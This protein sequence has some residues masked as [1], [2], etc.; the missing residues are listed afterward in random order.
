[1]KKTMFRWALCTLAFLPLLSVAQTTDP[2]PNT[3][4]SLFGGGGLHY[5]TFSLGVNGGITAPSVLIGGSNDFTKS[6]IS[7]GY[8]AYA[9]WQ[10]LHFFSL[11]ADYMGGRLKGD[12][13]RELGNGAD[14]NRAVESF[15][16]RLKWTASLSGVF[17]F[18]TI[19]WAYR[20]PLAQFYASVGGGLA[21]YSP[22][23]TPANGTEQEYKPDGN[24]KEL[25]IPVGAGIK[26]RLNDFLN[27][28]L[29][30]TMHFVDGDNL[31]GFNYGNS[32]D[33]FSYGY[34][35][36]E[37][38]LGARTKPQLQWHN[39]PAVMYDDLAAQRDQLRLELEAEKNNNAKLA[40]DLAKLQADSDGDGVSDVFDKCPNTPSGD[41]V[42]GS[43]CSLPKPDTARPVQV[44]ITEDDRRLVKNAIDNLEF[45]TGKSDIRPKSYASLNEVA[46]LM[47]RKNLSLK[48]AGHTDNTGNRALNMRLSKDR[49]E[50]VKSYLVS[51]GVNPSRIEATGYGQ[52]QPI[53]SNK[54]A[55]GRQQNRRVEFTIY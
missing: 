11:R 37:F 44:I 18:G 54:T 23:I 50:S 31:D 42:D 46:A 12:Q 3:H 40:A 9:K 19:N 30:Y 43:G 36:L 1:M 47:V 25:V 17:N 28:D 15:E 32:K 26:F 48:L 29:G 24:I 51:K 49:A 41:K 39:A 16:T 35:G 6:L 52:D 20:K 4:S 33:R 14:P 8:G 13:S 53:A 27:L 5:R 38:A 7:F 55:A 34:A 22:R 21:G 45:E 10:I 2:A